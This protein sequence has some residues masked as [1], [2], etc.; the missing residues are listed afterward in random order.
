MNSLL[1]AFF[2]E[3]LESFHILPL[4]ESIVQFSFDLVL[5]DDLRTLD[6]LQ[7]SA[8]LSIDPGQETV[9]FV[10]ADSELV[11]VAQKHDLDTIHPDG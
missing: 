2:V 3:A 9:T 8:A 5:R 7:L 11:S 4:E 1:N 10:S 6:S